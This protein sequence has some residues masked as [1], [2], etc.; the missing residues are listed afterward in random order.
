MTYR[1]SKY[2]LLNLQVNL[3]DMEMLRSGVY[4]LINYVGCEGSIGEVM[5]GLLKFSKK[6]WIFGCAQE[7]TF[8]KDTE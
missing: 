5:R 4:E 1:L 3:S 8:P 7:G 2:E 6:F